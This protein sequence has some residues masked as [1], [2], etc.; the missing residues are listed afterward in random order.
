MRVHTA[1]FARCGPR[2][3]SGPGPDLERGDRRVTTAVNEGPWHSYCRGPS[4]VSEPAEPERSDGSAWA[5]RSRSARRGRRASAG[6]ATRLDAPS[7]PTLRP[8]TALAW[9]GAHRPRDPPLPREVD[10]R[11]GPR[12]RRR[13]PPRSG[14]R[15]AATPSSTATGGSRPEGQPTVP[16]PRRGLPLRRQDRRRRDR[17]R[18][19]PRVRRDGRR[20][21]P[22]TTPLDAELSG[23][24]AIAVQRAGLE[25]GTSALRRRCGLAGRHRAARVVLPASSASTPIRGGCAPTWSVETAEPFEEEAWV[26]HDVCDRSRPS[27]SVDRARSN[28]A[29]PS[30]SP[31]TASPPRL[32]WLKALG[33][34]GATSVWPCSPTWPPRAARRSATSSPCAES[35]AWAADLWSER[36]APVDDVPAPVDDTPDGEISPVSWGFLLRGWSP[37]DIELSYALPP[38]RAGSAGRRRFTPR[39]N[40]RRRQGDEAAGTGAEG[41]S[42]GSVT[43]TGHTE[44]PL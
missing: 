32:P 8:R 18:H 43:G 3:T 20:G 2:V 28:A 33:A 13:R 7:R 36:P 27:C 41:R 12:P 23:R 5:R 10:G 44:G 19:P 1:G 15:P 40:P 39:G 30:T 29:A 4:P 14:R 38:G 11:R 25:S 9:I 17:P 34:S 22:A 35:T 31:R 16:A 6:R 37:Q 42:I 21:P 26:G 24:S